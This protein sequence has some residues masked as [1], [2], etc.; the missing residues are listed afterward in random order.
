MLYSINTFSN[1]LVLCRCAH[2]ATIL[3]L[4]REG[5]LHWFVDKHQHCF[6]IYIL[7]V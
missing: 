5:A 2:A 4:T 6:T 3:L 1:Q 7:N